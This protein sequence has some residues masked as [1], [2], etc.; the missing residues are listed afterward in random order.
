MET[1]PSQRN[2]PTSRPGS[3]TTVMCAAATND[4]AL[5]LRAAMVRDGRIIE[6]RRFAPGER[7]TVGPT[8]RSTFVIRELDASMT[9][10]ASGERGWELCAVDGL[11]GRVLLESGVRDLASM[12]AGSDEDAPRIPLGRSARATLSLG[13]ATLLF[14][15]VPAPLPVPARALPP[16]VK[17]GLT[18]LID[19]RTTIIAAFSF[20]AHFGAMGSVYSDWF[21]T[22]SDDEASVRA[23]VNDYGKVLPPPP[24]IET[25]AAAQQDDSKEP[26]TAPTVGPPHPP[27]Q[28]AQNGGGSRGGPRMTDRGAA[29]LAAQLRA[30]G[31]GMLAVLTASGGHG[32]DEVFTRGNLPIGVIDRAAASAGGSGPG[33]VAS[34]GFGGNYGPVQPGVSLAAMPPSAT[35]VAVTQGAGKKIDVKGPK[36]ITTVPPPIIGGDLP[37][38][39]RVIAGL[40][41]QF[42]ACYEAGL[43]IDP[44]MKGST[45]IVAKVGPNGDVLSASA[46]GTAGLSSEVANC[47]AGKV[48][49]AALEPPKGGGATLVV[50]VMV[51]TQ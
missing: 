3:M 10:V 27:I 23:I 22:V 2:Q 8:E 29:D 43:R 20:L 14:E 19:W 50:P 21:D 38:A 9:V 49:N 37:D 17:T 32:T 16:G 15:I 26:K 13:G 48:R 44:E 47:I 18:D 34:L 45:R 33:G 28:T 30:A 5:H 6:E 39:P 12:A 1:T 24:P 46:T 41:G 4:A 36:T 42:R 35:T 7:I 31:D 40:R 25:Q 11:Q 51:T